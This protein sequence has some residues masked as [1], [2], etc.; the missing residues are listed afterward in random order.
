MRQMPMIPDAHA[1]FERMGSERH[2]ESLDTKVFRV[3][4]C[5]KALDRACKKVGA[6]SSHGSLG[7][8]LNIFQNVASVLGSK[9]INLI[10]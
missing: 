5:Q 9:S 4:E 10:A 6:D 7:S 1:F 3:S 2:R 8:R